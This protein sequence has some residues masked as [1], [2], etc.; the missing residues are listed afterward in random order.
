MTV[1]HPPGKSK[2]LAILWC[3]LALLC[4]LAL[5]ACST[6][7][8]L[9]RLFQPATATPRP[10]QPLSPSATAPAEASQPPQS[11][12]QVDQN[13]I[14]W[15]PPD[16]DPAGDGPAGKLL[17]ERLS[18]FEQANPGATVTVRVKAQGGAGGMLEALAATSAA[19]PGVA[20]ALVALSRSDLEV[21][22]LKGLI[23]SLDGLTAVMDD[24]DWYP[25]A[26]QLSQ[27]QGATF[28]LPFGGDALLMVYR[29]A[30]LGPPPADW[31]TVLRLGQ[32]LVFPAGDQQGL[33]TLTLYQMLGGPVSDDQ[34]RP[35]L[36]AD[37]LT[38]A[39]MLYTDGI[40]Q[41]VFPYWLS[42]IQNDRQA[43]QAYREQR[44]QWLVTWSSEY[45]KEVPADSLPVAL[46][47]LGDKPFTPATGMLW[48]LS[49]PVQERRVL[50]ARL[51]EFL[52]DRDFL[53]SL[54][55]AAGL[56]P[57][58][59]S[60]LAG[61]QDQTLRSVLSSVVLSAQLRPANDLMAALGPALQSA[62][63]QVIKREDDAS[64]AARSA[65]E[66]LAV[67]GVK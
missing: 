30:R 67:P 41:G 21:A 60:A 58:R 13:L 10:T 4:V 31:N 32:P 3:W 66:R 16:Y 22:A 64:Q 35:I 65:A 39:L 44:A 18:A 42:T 14:I 12:A 9:P 37:L 48:A 46:P 57:A 49:D 7:I 26:K 29:P 51:A 47:S 2:P 56:L 59:Q 5:P 62:T 38:K 50:S 28:G 36:Q 8:Q 20:P 19:A 54:T 43:W 23:T 15:V 33:F 45:L 11:T 24:P 63:L 1:Q 6:G 53:T 55:A 52:A 25:Y 17:A 40:S 34:K 27:I 61:Y